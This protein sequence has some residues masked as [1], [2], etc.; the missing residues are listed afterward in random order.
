[1]E[2]IGMEEIETITAPG[3]MFAV[4]VEAWEA[5]NTQWVYVPTLLDVH[6]QAVIFTFADPRWSMDR[7]TWRGDAVAHFVLRKFPGDHRPAALEL[8][9]DCARRT[10]VV[11]AGTACT[12]AE[13]EQ[14]LEA[15]F[16]K[17]PSRP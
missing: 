5:R 10:A 9:V 8:V 4:R 12:L 2:K 3:G 16:E 15:A 17:K 7:V 14:A 11:G 13:I 1:M 6:T